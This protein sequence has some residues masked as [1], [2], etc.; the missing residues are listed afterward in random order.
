MCIFG[1]LLEKCKIVFSHFPKIFH[2]TKKI[3]AQR[4]LPA[5]E[6]RFST[7]VYDPSLNLEQFPFLPAKSNSKSLLPPFTTT[8]AVIKQYLFYSLK[9][10]H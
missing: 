8:R 7:T 2:Y 1:Q 3:W 5:H 6:I 9:F 4:S 10:L